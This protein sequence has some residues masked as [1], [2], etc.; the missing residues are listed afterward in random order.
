MDRR[1][2]PVA[3]LKGCIGIHI[4]A[5]PG[6]KQTG[7]TDITTDAVGVQIAAPAREGEANATLVQFIAKAQT[8]QTDTFNGRLL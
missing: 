1:E 7:I 3:E 5:K 2:A 6:A 8:P 4:L